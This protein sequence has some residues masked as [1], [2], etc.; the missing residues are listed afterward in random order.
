MAGVVIFVINMLVDDNDGKVLWILLELVKLCAIETGV[1]GKPA[2]M[3][4][5][6]DKDVALISV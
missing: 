1:F 3:F 2:V 6:K 4:D 5:P